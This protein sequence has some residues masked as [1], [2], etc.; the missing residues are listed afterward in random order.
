ML[1]YLVLVLNQNYEPLNICRARRAVIL[2]Y[3]GKAEIVENGRG[4]IRTI[5]AV[6]QLPS[7]IRLFSLVRKPAPNRKLTRRE[8]FLRDRFIC[9]YCGQNTRELTLDHVI[10]R[11]RGGAHRWDNVVA[12]CIACNHK[13]AGRTPQEAG[14]RPLHWPK[15]PP[16]NP[17]QLFYP[18]LNS[19]QDW[20]KFIP[21]V[22]SWPRYSS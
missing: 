7:I 8:V 14:M 17:Y 9:Q 19:H 21:W 1:D 20:Q 5:S 16:A 22:A 3:Q 10:P 13:K 2:I 4:D 11:H 15:A 12:A 18:Y 6:F